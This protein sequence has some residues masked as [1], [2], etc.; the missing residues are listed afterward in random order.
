MA[1]VQEERMQRHF[2]ELQ[3]AENS[4]NNNN[5][6]QSFDFWDVFLQKYPLP[7][8]RTVDFEYPSLDI[9]S[10]QH[11]QQGAE[12]VPPVAVV[13]Q[14]AIHMREAETLEDL[15][16]CLQDHHENL[17]EHRPFGNSVY[18]NGGNNCVFMGAF[19][20]W[21]APGVAAQIRKTGH[22]AWQHAAWQYF[23]PPDNELHPYG[24]TDPIKAGIR[25]SGHLS[26]EGWEAL[27]PHKDN[28]SLYTVLIMLSDPNEYEGGELYMVVDRS[29]EQSTQQQD[30]D[31]SHPPMIVKPNQYSAVVFMADENSHQVLNI[32]G[33]DRRTVGTELWEYGDV[34]F[35]I[36]R[37]SPDM[38]HN[39][40]RNHDWW[41]FDRSD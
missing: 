2:E 33:G 1:E 28:M 30:F 27:G 25:T 16:Q 15:Q 5:N 41:D 39:F 7:L 9:L 19:L 22:L 24:Y 34:P 40:Q 18:S 26:Y 37:P 13:I 35:G 36:L 11:F 8:P 20:Q 10:Q 12:V 32:Q 3:T 23:V 6:N 38:W 4:D 31:K 29:G 14:N 21:L 17:R